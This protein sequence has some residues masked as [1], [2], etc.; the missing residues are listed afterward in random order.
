MAAPL[1]F[2]D[3][4]FAVITAVAAG[5]CLWAAG[6]VGDYVLTMNS[7]RMMGAMIAGPAAVETKS[8]GLASGQRL[9]FLSRPRARVAG[10]PAKTTQLQRQIGTAEVVVYIWRRMMWVVA[11]ILALIALL[12][13]FTSKARLLHLSASA[14]ILL[15]TVATLMGIRY[16]IAPEYGGMPP[17]PAKSYVCVAAVQ[18]LYGLIL[19][20]VF[21]RK[22]KVKPA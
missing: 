17:L 6:A 10:Q 21:A 19:L 22:P 1:V 13:W 8:S 7:A 18:S 9:P 3:R 2:R 14:V 4:V 11:G 16:L 5:L 12:S 20:A 15:S